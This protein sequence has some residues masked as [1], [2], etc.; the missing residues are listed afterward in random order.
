[1]A[2]PAGNLLTDTFTRTTTNSVGTA[3]DGH[4]YTLVGSSSDFDCNGSRLVISNPSASVTHAIYPNVSNTLQ[5]DIWIEFQSTK[6]ATG[7]D[8]AVFACGR[9]TDEN[10]RYHARALQYPGGNLTLLLGRIKSGT[11][12][13]LTTEITV[14]TA[15]DITKVYVLRFRI[16]GP[17]GGSTPRLQAKLF[18]KSLGEPA[19]WAADF[20]DN[21]G[22]NH[23]TTSA[24]ISISGATFVGTTSQ[25]PIQVATLLA[26]DLSSGTPPPQ[27]PALTAVT[28]PGG[29]SVAAGASTTSAAISLSFSSSTP[30]TVASYTVAVDNGTASTQTSPYVITVATGSH[31]AV[32]TAVGSDGQT[33]ASQFTWTYATSG[34]TTQ[35]YTP[36]AGDVGYQIRALVT[37]VNSS[38]ASTPTATDWSPA[39]V[40]TIT[41]PS[42]T[43]APSISGQTA[44]GQVLTVSPGVWSGG[45]TITYTYQWKRAGSNISSA[46]KSTYTTV[47]ADVG[48]T[49]TCTVKATNSAGNASVTT[50]GVGPITNSGPVNTTAPQISVVDVFQVGGSL[51]VSDGVWSGAQPMTITY[52]WQRCATSGGTYTNIGGATS[53]TYTLQNADLGQYID[54]VV[55]ANNG[56]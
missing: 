47:S 15:F 25:N 1:M 48:N 50:A 46:T 31:K 21:D 30:P 55:T 23:I 38:G 54:C 13:P 39:V 49:I 51:T 17:A 44:T 4:T 7:G 12:T 14:D 52:Q 35:T 29:T 27:A 33:T 45:G 34:T 32:V 5:P 28:S 18:K 56:F 40:A 11:N 6:A 19:S 22:T 16:T 41:T 36:Q 42:N 3:D 9:A 20:T 37:G 24:G 8:V 26:D 53:N 2:A 10:N 43:T